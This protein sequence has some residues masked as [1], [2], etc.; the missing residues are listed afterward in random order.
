MEKTSLIQIRVSPDFKKE[1]TERA[2]KLNMTI[3]AYLTYLASKDLG[4]L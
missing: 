3:T 4:K 1:L 2:K